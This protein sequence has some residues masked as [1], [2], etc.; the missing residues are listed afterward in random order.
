MD[1]L[2]QLL[3]DTNSPTP[4]AP[5]KIEKIKK[6]AFVR[7]PPREDDTPIN[8]MDFSRGLEQVIEDPLPLHQFSEFKP[9]D[10]FS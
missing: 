8:E 9:W 3:R 4:P 5:P 6:Y 7:P 2:S 10:F 1:S